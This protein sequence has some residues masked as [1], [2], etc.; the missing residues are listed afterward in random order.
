MKIIGCV[1]VLFLGSIFIRVLFY[2]GGKVL[3]HDVFEPSDVLIAAFGV[4]A[5]WACR[6]VYR[7][8]ISKNLT[9]APPQ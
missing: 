1:T 6:V 7:T 2:F 4:G 9:K 3:L 8:L 5:L